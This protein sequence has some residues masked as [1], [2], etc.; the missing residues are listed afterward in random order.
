MQP[1]ASF[2]IDHTLLSP[3]LYL[4]REDGDI[5]TFDLRFVHPNQPPFLSVAAMHTIEHLFATYVRN[6]PWAD[7]IVYFGPMGCRTG[8]YF[9]TRAL[10]RETAILLTQKAVSFIAAYDGKIPGVSAAECGNFREHDLSGA[11][12]YAQDYQKAIAGW[13]I[14]QLQYP[15]N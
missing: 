11:R 10:P 1:I 7:N 8:F 13:T 5:D 3:G 4:S 9:L 6:S 12:T 14:D 2:T 15:R